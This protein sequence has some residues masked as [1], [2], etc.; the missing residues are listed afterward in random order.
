MIFICIINIIDGCYLIYRIA[1]KDFDHDFKYVFAY[2]SIG[3]EIVGAALIFSYRPLIDSAVQRVK[4]VVG[5][6]LFVIC[7]ILSNIS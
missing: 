2:V 6:F 1:V 5:C 3:L 4:F 7:L